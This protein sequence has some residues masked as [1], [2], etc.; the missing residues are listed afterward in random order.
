[1]SL[2]KHNKEN[3][4]KVYKEHIKNVKK[5]FK[6]RPKDLLIIDFSKNEGWKEICEFLGKDIPNSSFPHANKTISRDKNFIQKSLRKFK[7]YR[8]KIK[9]LIK[10]AYINR[11]IG[12]KNQ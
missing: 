1:M 9:Y 4:I 3:T 5:Y 7:L 10:I 6:G 11:F 12:W 2:P 8:K